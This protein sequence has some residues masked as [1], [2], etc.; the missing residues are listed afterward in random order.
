MLPAD[1]AFSS[2]CK[3]AIS[4]TASRSIGRSSSMTFHTISKSTPKYS[5][6]SKFLKSFMSR[7]STSGRFFLNDSGSFP[8]ASPIISNSLITAEYVLLSLQKSSNE[9]L[10]QNSGWHCP[11]PGYHQNR[12][13]DPF[14]TYTIL[15]L[16]FSLTIGF[17][18]CSKPISTVLD[19]SC[20]KNLLN[21]KKSCMFFLPFSN[22]TIKSMS[23]E[24]FC[25]SFTKLP[26]RP[27]RTT[28]NL[29]RRRLLF[30]RR[31]SK[32]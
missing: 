30:A 27:R 22:S 26:K 23:L 32:I 11:N 29:S 7:H 5:C 1:H 20:S 10:L 12:D 31:K 4:R 8:T 13:E 17:N 18:D 21:P 14:Q 19:N 28:P 3:T 24:A 9:N 2:G 15:S 16:M 25:D 6:D